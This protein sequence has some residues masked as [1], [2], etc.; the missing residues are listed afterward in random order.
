MCSWATT[1]FH[2]VGCTRYCLQRSFVAALAR[3][4]ASR[5]AGWRHCDFRRSLH[6]NDLDCP[7]TP[8]FALWTLVHVPPYFFT[9]ASFLQGGVTYSVIVIIILP[10]TGCAPCAAHANSSRQKK[11]ERAH[12]PGGLEACSRRCSTSVLVFS[13]KWQDNGMATSAAF[14]SSQV[15]RYTCTQLSVLA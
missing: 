6:V 8:C 2:L 13:V 3:C 10:L 12:A 15:S 4:S 11:K 5:V 7:T 9:S 1:D 14:T